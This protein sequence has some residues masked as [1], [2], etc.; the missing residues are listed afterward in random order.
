MEGK[1]GREGEEKGEG[2]RKKEGKWKR[3]G[4][5]GEGPLPAL[6]PLRALGIGYSYATSWFCSCSS[7][8][9]YF[10]SRKMI[11]QDLVCP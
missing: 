11:R 4:K 6:F 10:F 5:E 9:Q 8:G 2:V 1:R 3:K 7:P